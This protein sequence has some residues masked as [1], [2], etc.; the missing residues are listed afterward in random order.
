MRFMYTP[1]SSLAKQVN[2]TLDYTLKLVSVYKFSSDSRHVPDPEIKKV[3]KP[4][5]VPLRQKKW[6][7][8]HSLFS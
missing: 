1:S 3:I 6:F 8:D 7:N 5:I 4:T 2:V